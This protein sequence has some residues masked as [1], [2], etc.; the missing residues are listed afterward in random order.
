MAFSKEDDDDD[1]NYI[2][3]YIY[4]TKT[5]K[6]FTVTRNAITCGLHCAAL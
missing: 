6:C 1:N 4:K 5:D 3:I 2:Y